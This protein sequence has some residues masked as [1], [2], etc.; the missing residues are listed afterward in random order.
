LVWYAHYPD[1]LAAIKRETQ[2]KVWKRDWKFEL[3][4]K[5]NVDWL[6]LH[7]CIEYRLSDG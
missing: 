4:E 7:Q 5:M 6:D 1:M 3:V 2:M